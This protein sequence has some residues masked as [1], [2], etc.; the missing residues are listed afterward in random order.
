MAVSLGHRPQ[1]VT[2]NGCAGQTAMAMPR[3]GFRAVGPKRRFP[4]SG[5][6]VFRRHGIDGF[7]RPFGRAHS[8]PT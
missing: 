7:T 5:D 2:A 3:V 6:A 4:C 1:S 8:M